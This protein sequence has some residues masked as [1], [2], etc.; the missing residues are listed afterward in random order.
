[1]PY[2]R[3]TTDSNGQDCIT[4]G[5]VAEGV[6][7]T[8]GATLDPVG[9]TI[10]EVHGLQPLDYPPCPE[11]PRV[12]GEAAPAETRV[13]IALRQWERIALP[14]PQPKIAPNRAITG[15]LA[16]LETVGQTTLTSTTETMYGP[17]TIIASGAYTVNWGDGESSGPHLAEGKA[18]PEGD[19]THIYQRVGAYDIR[20]TERWTATWSLDGESGVLRTLQTSGQI[21]QF[22]VEQVQ[23]VIR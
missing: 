18:W 23:A 13:M 11:E 22:P 16:Y 9:Q 3:L 6:A 4:T 10:R 8:D 5:Y 20:V 7:P 15:K 12:P 14:I 21:D 17:L 19:I 1:V 2:L